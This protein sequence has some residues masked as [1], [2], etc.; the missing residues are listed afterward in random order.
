MVGVRLL[1]EALGSL[2]GK[3]L[4]KLQHF[5]FPRGFPCSGGGVLHEM[6]ILLE[7]K[8]GPGVEGESPEPTL[9]TSSPYLA[10]PAAGISSCHP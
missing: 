10:P 7:F 4:G 3:P 8:E 2:E 5:F 6:S 9:L 1:M